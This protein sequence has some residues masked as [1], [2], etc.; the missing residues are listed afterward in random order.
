MKECCPNL[1]FRQKWNKE[2]RNFKKE[3]MV[4]VM[5]EMMSRGAWPPG[6]ILELKTGKD[7]L[8]WTVLVKTMKS[9]LIRPICKIRLFEEVP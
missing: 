6:R 9:Q 5:D 1:Q 3:N 4:L 7:D 2:C 8:V